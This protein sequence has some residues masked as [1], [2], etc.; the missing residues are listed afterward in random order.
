MMAVVDTMTIMMIIARG[1]TI[2][3][4]IRKMIDIPVKGMIVISMIRE[5]AIDQVIIL[6]EMII[7]IETMMKTDQEMPIIMQQGLQESV[8]FK[9]FI[10]IVYNLTM[11]LVRL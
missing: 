9:F 2:L 1:P 5:M 3:D 4:H 10:A 11:V 7:V 6:D 8:S